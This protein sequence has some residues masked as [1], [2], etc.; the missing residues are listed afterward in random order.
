LSR[1]SPP[2]SHR[3]GDPPARTDE[4]SRVRPREDGSLS[5][6]AEDADGGIQSRRERTEEQ[7]RRARGVLAK[8]PASD[9]RATLLG[10]AVQRRDLVLIEAVLADLREQ[11]TIE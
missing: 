3:P 10:L 11:G 1:L 4:R 8:L 7:L 9:P 2:P 5:V 6:R